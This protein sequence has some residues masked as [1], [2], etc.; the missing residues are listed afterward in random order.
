MEIIRKTLAV[1]CVILFAITVV[2]AL[3]AFNFEQK[4]F[5]PETYQTA[6]AKDE[7]YNKLPTLM[8][9]IMT[10]TISNQND[11]PIFLQGFDAA[12]WEN[13]FRN[14]LPPN[15]LKA[16]GDDALYSTLA[17]INMETD[18]VHLT[19]IPLKAS[20]ASNSAVQAIYALLET[21]PAC[22]IIQIT[23][24]GIDLFIGGQI[25][26]CS[27]PADLHPLLTPVIQDQLRFTA[28]ALPDK[29][30]IV[31]APLQ[32]DPRPGLINTRFIMR[33]SPILP[34]ILLF[35]LT[36]LI[37]RSITDWLSW[38]GIPF[39]ISGGIAFLMSLL[40]APLV[41]II[42]QGILVTRLP[43]YL[44]SNLL[45]FSGDLASTM[46]NALLRPVMWQGLIIAAFGMG[47]TISFY[48]VK[49]RE[50]TATH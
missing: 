13:F 2:I 45:D 42:L 31:H 35:T 50:V 29:V 22:T 46:A 6:F 12:S 49:K 37:V 16:M 23:Q 7:F 10:S 5:A 1:I 28:T 38:W 41:K 39:L 17:Y 36:I 27:P 8:A 4:A 21:Q 48:F 34:I 19:L 9:E 32:N 26:L 20:L 47:M 40:G 18:T 43:A 33:F 15:V 24:M 44:P 3:F 25:Q 11:F 14:L 30:E